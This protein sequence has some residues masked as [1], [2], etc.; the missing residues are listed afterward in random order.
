[1]QNSKSG[2]LSRHETTTF[3]TRVTRVLEA[4][5]LTSFKGVWFISKLGCQMT[6]RMQ[7]NK[8]SVFI[9]KSTQ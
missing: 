3:N 2:D 6:N 1:M 5:I 9:P 4:K 8:F 7:F